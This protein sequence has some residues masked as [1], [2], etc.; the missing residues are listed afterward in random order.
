MGKYTKRQAETLN[1]FFLYHRHKVSYNN[2]KP[3]CLTLSVPTPWNGQTYSKN[4]TAR[5]NELFEC[6]L[7]C[8]V[9][10]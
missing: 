7:F 9:G 8:G 6:I 4:L 1:N 5:V 3:L 10:P 2:T